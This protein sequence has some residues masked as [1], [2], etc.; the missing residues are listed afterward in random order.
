MSNSMVSRIAIYIPGINIY[1]QEKALL[2]IAKLLSHSYKVIIFGH[3]KWGKDISEYCSKNNLEY[4]PLISG[5][6]WSYSLFIKKPTII[7]S[8]LYAFFKTS[9][10]IA[11]VNKLNKI[12]ILLTGNSIFTFYA[13]IAIKICRIKLIFR[14]GDELPRHNIVNKIIS[15]IVIKSAKKIFCNCFYLKKNINYLYKVD[16]VVIRN[17]I[18]YS[19]NNNKYYNKIHNNT[20]II[21]V[22]QLTKEKGLL[23]LL[24]T[25]SNILKI[26]NDI[27]FTIIGSEPGYKYTKNSLITNK[28]AKLI[29]RYPNNILHKE[30]TPNLYEFYSRADIHVC[31]SVYNEPS[32]NVIFEAKAHSLPSIIFNVGGLPELIE[33]EVD[34][35]CGSQ[36]SSKELVSMIIRLTDNIELRKKLSLNAFKSIDN[37][38]NQNIIKNKI[39]ETI[40]DN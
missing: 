31:P 2:T 16:S 25:I 27:S 4:F 26:R 20:N 22:G 10:K 38:F 39:I 29:A 21:Y 33:N 23:I 13:L 9:Y 3:E 18:S 5:S 24:E 14:A 1:G 30:F 15:Y 17:I 35:L 28:I 37:N 34:G 11:T 7:F 6:I 12:D 8:N 32:A 36:I 19:E 40:T